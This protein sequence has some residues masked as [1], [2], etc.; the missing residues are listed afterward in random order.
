MKIM[1]RNI[2]TLVL[3]CSIFGFSTTFAQKNV[4][5]GTTSPDNSA[6]LDINSSDKGLLIPRMSLQQRNAINNPADGL[7]VY[8]TGEQGG[9]YFFEGKT[10]EWKPIT[11]AKSI[12]GTDGDWTLIGNAA[13]LN[14]FIGTTNDQPLRFKVG[15]SSFGQFNRAKASV[16]IGQDAGNES[17]TGNANTG[18][19]LN[20]LTSV[21]T[22]LGNTA[23]GVN[24]MASGS[25]TGQFNIGL[26]NGS[27]TNLTGGS[28]N[29][30]I[31]WR[32][33]S[34]ITSGFYNMGIGTQA[35]FNNNV[36]NNNVAIGISSMLANTDGSSNTAIGFNSLISNVNG[37][38][39]VAI[40]N[41]AGADE[42][43]SNKLYIANSNTVTPLIY[44]DFS[45]KFVSIGDVSVSKRSAAGTGG[46]NLLV[47]GGI[48]TEK[49]KVALANTTDWADYVFEDSYS[50][51]PLSEVEAFTK[52]NKHLPNVPSA[53]EMVNN[54]LDVGQTS[55]ML[56]EKIEE[57]T[58]YLIEL[59]KEV[60]ELKAENGE[61]KA[62]LK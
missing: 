9:F 61:L 35:L 20:A 42:T 12:A 36:G 11:E 58:L 55:K 50:L 23:I 52:A 24:A 45:A 47:K 46:Y 27:L 57:L 32:A 43:G 1:K 19:G 56:M 54:G 7:M 17:N 25:I 39:N 4:G 49:V 29:V 18:I 51:M 26:G 59:N 40:G 8:Q 14:D 5:I 22:G 13:G 48:L 28:Q 41:A 30:G 6:V 37:D 33:L 62:K 60:Q 15:N 38:G 21:S 2:Y 10:N 44:G 16:F 53:D 34:R 3:L 31:G